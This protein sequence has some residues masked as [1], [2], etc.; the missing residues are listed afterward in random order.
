MKMTW[1]TINCVLNRNKNKGRLPDSL[2]EKNR[3]ISFT[4]Q[5]AIAN[6][7][8]EYFVN[9]GPSLAKKFQ[10]DD[11]AMFKKYLKGNYK[12]NMFAHS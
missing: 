4:H 12:D 8:N 1:Q 7:F 5:V 2:R 3:N 9:A 6:K 11:T 10:K